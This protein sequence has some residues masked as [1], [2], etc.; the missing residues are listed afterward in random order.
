MSDFAGQATWCVASWDD[1]VADR[2]DDLF[3]FEDKN[4][5]LQEMMTSERHRIARILRDEFKPC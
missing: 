2:E 3:C 4:A 5:I 1:V